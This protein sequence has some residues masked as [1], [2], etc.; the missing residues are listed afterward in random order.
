MGGVISAFEVKNKVTSF[1]CV[2]RLENAEIVDENYPAASTVGEIAGLKTCVPVVG[3]RHRLDSFLVCEQLQTEINSSLWL[4][5]YGQFCSDA[6][7]MG[8]AWMHGAEGLEFRDRSMVLGIRSSFCSLNQTQ[9]WFR[10]QT[11]MN[12]FI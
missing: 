3:S 2:V 8:Q 11:L 5:L 6:D 1:M 7:P 4:P 9:E 10:T 12:L